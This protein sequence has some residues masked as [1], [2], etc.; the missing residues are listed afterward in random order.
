MNE[1]RLID[2]VQYECPMCT[3]KFYINLEDVKEFPEGKEI[4][5]PCCDILTVPISRFFKMEIVGYVDNK[6]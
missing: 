6:Q 5:C 3:K 1:E 2:L 4:A